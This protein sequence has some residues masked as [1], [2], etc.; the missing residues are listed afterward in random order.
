[1]PDTQVLTDERLAALKILYPWY[2]E[3]VF[4]RRE[5][6]VRLTAF[7]SAFLVLLLVTM[8]AMPVQPR[9]NFTGEVFALTGV[10]LFSG[11]FGYLILQQRDRHQMAKQ[12]LIEVERA[13]GFY[14]EGLYLSAQPLY[15]EHWQHAWL[16]DRSVTIYLTILTALTVLV[17]AAVLIRSFV[18]DS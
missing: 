11:L 6:M 17:M 15:P 4:R 1:M 13:L 16:A 9:Q 8:L 12:A 10:A 18:P 5:Q 7:A 3:E 14:E 2:K